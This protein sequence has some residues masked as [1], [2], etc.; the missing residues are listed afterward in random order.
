MW[1]GGHGGNDG[2]QLR[3][4]RRGASMALHGVLRTGLCSI[5]AEGEFGP[6]SMAERVSAGRQ[7][8]AAHPACRAVPGSTA[9]QD[10]T[11]R[12]P[13]AAREV[14]PTSASRK[15]PWNSSHPSS[16]SPSVRSS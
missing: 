14:L 3:P 13:L 8:G 10:F 9:G 7:H 4:R 6:A 15:N 1:D 5:P 12:R 2:A 16:G 11:R